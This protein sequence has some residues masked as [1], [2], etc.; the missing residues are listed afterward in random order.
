M[1]VC[2]KR[3]TRYGLVRRF[4]CMVAVSCFFPVYADAAS[5]MM[6]ILGRPTADDGDLYTWKV[7]HAALER[8]KRGYG[9]FE[10]RW[11]DSFGMTETRKIYEMENAALLINTM[12]LPTRQ[13]LE[14]RLV[15]AKIPIDHSLLGFRVF[16]I[17]AEDQARFD[18]IHT[19]SDL[20]SIRIG[21]GSDW[22]DGDIL[23]HAGLRVVRGSGYDG[24]FAMLAAGRFDAFSRGVYEAVPE[25][26]A[27]RAEL[28][29][30]V[31]EK[32]ILLYYP[33]PVYFWFPNTED[34]RRRAKRVEE[35]VAGMVADGTLETIFRQQYCAIL[36]RLDLKHRRLFRIENPQIGP[37]K[38]PTD[39]PHLCEKF[40]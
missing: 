20:Q 2:Q 6:Y 5:P 28:P 30:V 33:M 36:Q 4:I 11:A 22:V 3:Q 14:E 8:T 16:L 38:S 13:S 29:G 26:D 37:E 19:L 12:V 17:R 10:L 24:L 31:I 40:E 18:A 21:Q 7:L 1:N 27:R 32:G 23:E 35:G 25:L 15:P 9:E 39:L 34:G